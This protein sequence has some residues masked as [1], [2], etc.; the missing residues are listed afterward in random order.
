[1]RGKGPLRNTTRDLPYPLRPLTSNAQLALRVSFGAGCLQRRP[2]G[3]VAASA[4]SGSKPPG[5]PGRP[6]RDGAKGTAKDRRGARSVGAQP[7]AAASRHLPW[8]NRRLVLRCVG[9]LRQR[10]SLLQLP[11]DHPPP[12]RP[13]HQRPRLCRRQGNLSLG[14]FQRQSTHCGQVCRTSTPRHTL[15]TTRRALMSAMCLQ[16]RHAADRRESA[17][18]PAPQ[19]VAGPAGSRRRTASLGGRATSLLPGSL[20]SD[21]R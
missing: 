14:P 9:V 17:F 18:A 21:S 8:P 16:S 10:V 4:R 11:I 2:Q 3:L 20:G 7:Y 12:W 13:W 1:M 5:D 6:L 19:P 15:G